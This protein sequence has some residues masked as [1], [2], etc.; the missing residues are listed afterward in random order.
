M[1][2]EGTQWSLGCVIFFLLLLQLI[3]VRGRDGADH[4]LLFMERGHGAITGLPPRLL[5]VILIIIVFIILII[6]T[7]LL[8]HSL[9]LLLHLLVLFCLHRLTRGVG[10]HS[11]LDILR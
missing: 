3:L 1:K 6:I 5:T 11:P 4:L 7:W 8:Q 2:Q 9:S 10:L